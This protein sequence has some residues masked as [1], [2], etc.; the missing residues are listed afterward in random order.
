MTLPKHITDALEILL[1]TKDN[2]AGY[3]RELVEHFILEEKWG[4]WLGRWT[5]EEHLHAIAL[6]EVPGGHPRDRPDRQRGRPRR[7]RDEGLPRRH[8]QPDRDAGLHGVLRARARGVLPQSGRPDRGAGTGGPDR[9]GSPGTRSATRS[10]SPTSSRTAWRTTAT[11]RSRRSRAAPA[12]LDVV[13]ADIDAYKDKIAV[14]ADAGI[15]DEAAA[16]PGDFRPHHRVGRG[17]RAAT[18]RVR[19]RGR[20]RFRSTLLGG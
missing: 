14:V 4:R 16:A 18:S 5:A 7:A 20:P 15:F 12:D 2:L 10:S 17:R 8:V 1:I 13:G 9:A 19:E 3:H 6:R 11:R